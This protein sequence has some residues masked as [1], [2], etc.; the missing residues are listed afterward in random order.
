MVSSPEDLSQRG[1]GLL[2]WL[3]RRGI[4]HGFILAAAAAARRLPAA[5]PTELRPFSSLV[6]TSLLAPGFLPRPPVVLHLPRRLPIDVRV[7]RQ[8]GCTEHQHDGHQRPD[9]GLERCRR[10]SLAAEH[11]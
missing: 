5:D 7:H 1:L 8:R 2:C 10:H 6:E 3:R 9:L 11:L 4:G